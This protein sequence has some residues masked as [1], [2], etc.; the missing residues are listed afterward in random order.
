RAARPRRCTTAGS[1]RAASPAASGTR[2]RAPARAAWRFRPPPSPATGAAAAATACPGAGPPA[3]TRASPRGRTGPATRTGRAAARPRQVDATAA[4]AFQWPGFPKPPA[5]RSMST[6]RI[7]L[8]DDHPIVRSGFRQL[9]ELEPGWQVIAE[10]GSAR[11]LA[12]WMLHSTC[13]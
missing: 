3:G 9:L 5:A 10:V 2:A 4:I 13:D 6:L 8:V 1:R 7:V 11:E 12:A